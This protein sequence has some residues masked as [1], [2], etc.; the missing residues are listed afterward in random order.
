MRISVR[1]VPRASRQEVTAEAP[2]IYKIYV[3]EPALDGRANKRL[4]EMLAV[5]FA[6]KKNRI[7]IVRGL[8]QR[9]KIVE[10]ET[11]IKKR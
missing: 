7:R 10:I 11:E 6:T 1:L 5:H 9:D 8:K 4:I 3:H 2:N